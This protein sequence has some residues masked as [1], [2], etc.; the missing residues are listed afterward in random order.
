MKRMIALTAVLVLLTGCGNSVRQTEYDDLQRKYDTL[1][2]DYVAL[3]SK[4]QA[5]ARENI[6]LTSELSYHKYQSGE[7]TVQGVD[8]SSNRE[9]LVTL[10]EELGN[11]DS[12]INGTITDAICYLDENQNVSSITYTI[13]TEKGGVYEG[14][15]MYDDEGYVQYSTIYI[16]T[17]YCYFWSRDAILFSDHKAGTWV[18]DC[19][20]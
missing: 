4:Y 19:L 15:N 20:S 10:S 9:L 13:Q 7:P 1:N 5:S 14:F 8:Q 17:E 16:N 11:I 3:E 6:E 18:L 2:T 12:K